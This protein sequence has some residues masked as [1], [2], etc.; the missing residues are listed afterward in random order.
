MRKKLEGNGLWESSRMMLPEHKERILE[1]NH[2]LDRKEKPILDPYKREEINERLSNAYRN[3]EAVRLVLWDPFEN[4]SIS[5][6]ITKLDVL[7][8][9]ILIDGQWVKLTGILEVESC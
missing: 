6:V 2:E 3:G 7:A 4:R 1:V 9:R 8:Y 5:G